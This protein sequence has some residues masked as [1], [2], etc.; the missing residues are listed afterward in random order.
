MHP[1]NDVLLAGYHRFHGE[2]GEPH[3]SFEVY[4]HGGGSDTDAG[5][6][7][8]AC[9]PGCLPDGEPAGPFQTAQAAIDDA[10]DGF[11]PVAG[12]EAHHHAPWFTL[13][14]TED[15]GDDNRT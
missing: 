1:N 12:E 4:W 5:W 7:W 13:D 11:D 3:G 2:A 9:F 6:Y 15:E 8:Q 14:V 10:D